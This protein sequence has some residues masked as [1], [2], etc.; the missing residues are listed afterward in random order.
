M[1]TPDTPAEEPVLRELGW[2]TPEVLHW[3]VDRVTGPLP[4]DAPTA[5]EVHAAIDAV[6]QPL[7]TTT[8]T[9]RAS[10]PYGGF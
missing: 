10:G 7:A 9:V 4:A 1:S 8:T 6:H 3:L 2:G 5:A